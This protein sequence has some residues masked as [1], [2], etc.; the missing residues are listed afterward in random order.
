[1]PITIKKLRHAAGMLMIPA[2]IFGAL[3]CSD[4]PTDSDSSQNPWDLVPPES[5]GLSP[6]VLEELTAD[7]EAGELGRIN[8][9][10]ILRNGKL[11]YEEYF[12]GFDK[13]DLQPLSFVTMGVS[14][15]LIGIALEEGLIS[16]L[17]KKISCFFQEYDIPDNPSP[18]KGMITVRD[19]LEMRTGLG[20]SELGISYS[21]LTN[22]ACRMRNSADRFKYVLDCP[23]A[24]PP[25][26][27]WNYNSGAAVLLAAIIKCATGRQADQYAQ[28]KLFRPLGIRDYYWATWSRDAESFPLT[29]DGL[30]LRPR[31][32]AKIGCLY[33]DNGAWHG[34]TIISPAWI[35]QATKP[36]IPDVTE[37]Q[38]D[39]G[40]QWWINSNNGHDLPLVF[41]CGE[42]C[43]LICKSLKLVIVLMA[44]NNSEDDH[45]PAW[46]R[47]CEDYLPRALTQ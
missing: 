25:G 9:L 36:I 39:Y 44:D 23:M 47:L 45:Q 33:V 40:L 30:K 24:G 26:Q 19:L 12:R 18:Y 32:L 20:W 15:T 43:L 42:Q 5:Q 28:E 7:I 10:L 13:N 27:N 1:M 6:Q 17:D 21:S 29:D 11:V 16:G 38:L 3:S 14:S 37:N 2:L 8:S 4:S 31:D 46:A 34:E 22:S 35:E 41:G